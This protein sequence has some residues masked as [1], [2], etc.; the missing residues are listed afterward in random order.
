M[1]RIDN[2]DERDAE[3]WKLHVRGHSAA[4]IAE[5][6]GLSTSRVTQILTKIRGT[7][8]Q[9]KRQELILRETE[10]LDEL[11]VKTF[12]VLDNPES[13]AEK[14]AAIREVTKNSESVR[15]MYGADAPQTAR[16]EVA[17]DVVFTLNIDKP[18][19]EVDDDDATE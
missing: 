7:I 9:F 6:Y 11:R 15:K 4:K 16:V 17:D 18:K 8:S 13:N 2:N 3:M 10:V 1:L 14:L 5:Q 12:E 19:G